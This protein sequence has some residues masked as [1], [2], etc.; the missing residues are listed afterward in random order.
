MTN[1]ELPSNA[2]W[3]HF[4]GSGEKAHFYHANGFPSGV[5]SR[6]LAALSQRL[7]LSALAC[8]ATWPNIGLPPKRR[9]WQ[10]YADDLITFIEHQYQEPIIGIG[11]SMGATCT[12]LAAEKRPE[13]FKALVLI[14]TAM[15]SKPLATIARVLPKSFMTMIE[16][17]KSTLK[18]PDTWKSR[19][20]FLAD[21]RRF[22]GYKRFDDEAFDTLAQHGLVE[23]PAG[24]FKLSF[25]REWEAHNYTQPPNVLANLERLNMPCI[26]IRGKPSVFFTEAMWH[27]WQDRCP[28]TIFKQNLDYGH[29]FPLENPS[30]C[31]ELIDAGLS[32]ISY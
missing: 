32:E 16:P 26:A 19:E 2:I 30:I 28:N 29:L 27:D 7:D 8:R 3:K 17:A 31:Y 25:P 13:L 22:R 6:L 24:H 12:I 5:Y 1:N 4:G 23:T 15:L 20:A 9:D 14:E 21:C 18:K 11:H 10:I